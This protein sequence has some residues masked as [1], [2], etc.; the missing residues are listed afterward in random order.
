MCHLSGAFEQRCLVL[1]DEHD[2]E[3]KRADVDVALGPQ[4]FEHRG[5]FAHGVVLD[6]EHA[7]FVLLERPPLEQ[8]QFRPL[9]IDDRK[10]DRRPGELV[11]VGLEDVVHGGHGDADGG[12]GVAGCFDGV[13]V[14]G[15]A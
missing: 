13:E 8:A 10:V 11:L 6:D 12:G 3:S 7:G 15:R 1:M 2:V 14:F 5:V 4:V 9:D